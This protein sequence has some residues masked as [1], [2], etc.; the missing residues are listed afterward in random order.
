MLR[1][2]TGKEIRSMCSFVMYDFRVAAEWPL[3]HYGDDS[4]T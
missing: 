4:R 2:E 3:P 1:R